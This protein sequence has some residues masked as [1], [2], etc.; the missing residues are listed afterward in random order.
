MLIQA[1]KGHSSNFCLISQLGETYGRRMTTGFLNSQFP[2]RRFGETR[3]GQAMRR[4]NPEQQEIRRQ[5]I[6]ILRSG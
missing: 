1:S 4:A 5:V 6:F 2:T 3:V